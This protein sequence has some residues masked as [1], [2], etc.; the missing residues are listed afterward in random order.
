[1]GY[2]PWPLLRRKLTQPNGSFKG[3][4]VHIPGQPRRN[5]DWVSGYRENM[6]IR[7]QVLH[8]PK[9][10]RIASRCK[11]CLQIIF[12]C[13]WGDASVGKV[14]TF[15]ARGSE[16]RPQNPGKKRIR[17][18]DMEGT[19][20]APVQGSGNSWLPET[21]CQ[22][23]RPNQYVLGKVGK[24]SHCLKNKADFW[25]HTYTSTEAPMPENTHT[26]TPHHTVM[27]KLGM[28][29]HSSGH[30]LEAGRWKP[31]SAI[32]LDPALNNNNE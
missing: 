25:L 2:L 22:Q 28:V 29:V 1:M 31:V 15:Q 17:R 27:L 5:T 9:Q 10:V 13:R 26:W 32:E 19:L 8:L 4:R 23:P 30:H 24:V 6:G 20:T 3:G 12:L 16:S 21:A 18:G 7:N 14:N 11:P